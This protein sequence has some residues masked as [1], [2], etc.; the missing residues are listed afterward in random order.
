[1]SDAP[2]LVTG[3][4][5]G[6]GFACARQLAAGGATPVWIA[7]RDAARTRAAADTINALVG[8]AAAQA[9]TLDLASLSAVSQFTAT[10]REQLRARGQWLQAIVCNAGV[11]VAGALSYTTDGFETMFGVNHLAHFLLVQQLMPVLAPDARIVVVSS[12]TH[13]PRSIDGRFNAPQFTTPDALAW[14][15]RTNT[16]PMIAIRRY[17]TTKLCNLYFAYELDRRLR[18]GVYGDEKRGVT[19]NA[20]DPGATPGTGLVRD[21]PGWMQ[22]L[23]SAPLTARAL[24]VLGLRT[25]PVDRVGRALARLVTDPMLAGHS[26]RYFHVETETPSSIESRDMHAAK[27]LWEASERMTA[28]FST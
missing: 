15:E 11:Q 16:R 3:A 8:E 17:A 27:L 2:I 7:S 18:R 26:G 20:Y 23:W 1:M 4:S 12:G 24:G 9:L 5:S 22:R 10:A 21:Y 25:Y 13:D 28:G 19:V 6:I 14:P